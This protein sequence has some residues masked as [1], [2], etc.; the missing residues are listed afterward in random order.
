MINV[1]SQLRY[2]L[3]YTLLAWLSFEAVI[4]S[5]AILQ[6][7]DPSTYFDGTAS[8][9]GSYLKWYAEGGME[10]YAH[11]IY[12][13]SQ[14]DPGE[15][16]ALHW[17]IVHREEEDDSVVIHVALVVPATGWISFGIAEAGG[18]PGADIMVYE[19]LSGELTDRFATAYSYPEL[20][21]S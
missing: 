6:A 8:E 3:T 4:G 12:L 19:A 15:G 14:S 20:D 11:S 9:D 17:S 1:S 10:R 7:E 5:D 21:A 18:M 16:L 2:L 13:P